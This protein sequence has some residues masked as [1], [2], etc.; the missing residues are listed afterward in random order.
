LPDFE[1]IA[2]ILEIYKSFCI[3]LQK[4]VFFE[5]FCK[6]LQKN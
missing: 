5:S 6:I 2:H 4:N 1:R 3:F